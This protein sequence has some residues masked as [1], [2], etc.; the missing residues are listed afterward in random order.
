MRGAFVVLALIACAVV[1]AAPIMAQEQ[2]TK[3]Q[4][5]DLYKKVESGA[6]KEDALLALEPK[7]INGYFKRTQTIAEMHVSNSIADRNVFRQLAQKILDGGEMPGSEVYK[8][9]AGGD[10]SDPSEQS[11]M[12]AMMAKN[13]GRMKKYLGSL[14]QSQPPIRR[15][16]DAGLLKVQSTGTDDET[17]LKQFEDVSFLQ[18]PPE[19]KLNNARISIVDFERL[20]KSGLEAIIDIRG[21][22]FVRAKTGSEIQLSGDIQTKEDK[23]LVLTSGRL[24]TKDGIGAEIPKTCADCKITINDI[25][26]IQASGSG[27]QLYSQGRLDKAGVL[28]GGA[29]LHPGFIEFVGGARFENKEGISFQVEKNT[30]YFDDAKTFSEYRKSGKSAILSDVYSDTKTGVGTRALT[31]SAGKDN[32]ITV[33]YDVAHAYQQTNLERGGGAVLIRE[34]RGDKLSSEFGIVGERPFIS[35]QDGKLKLGAP[36]TFV[37]IKGEDPSK[38]QYLLNTGKEGVRSFSFGY[39]SPPR[40]SPEDLFTYKYHKAFDS[41]LTLRKIPDGSGWKELAL[42]EAGISTEPSPIE[43]LVKTLPSRLKQATAELES[44]PVPKPGKEGWMVGFRSL[45]DS[46]TSLVRKTLESQREYMRSR[47]ADPDLLSSP[48]DQASL[49]REMRSWWDAMGPN[50]RVRDMDKGSKLSDQQIQQLAREWLEDNPDYTFISGD[51]SGKV[52]SRK[53]SMEDALQKVRESSSQSYGEEQVDQMRKVLK[54]ADQKGATALRDELE[55]QFSDASRQLNDYADA[56]PEYKKGG[57]WDY[58]QS[59]IQQVIDV[60]YEQ[61]LFASDESR[62]QVLSAGMPSIKKFQADVKVY[63]GKQIPDIAA[64]LTDAN[65][66]E[67]QLPTELNEMLLSKV[68]QKYQEVE[69]YFKAHGSFPPG[70]PTSHPQLMEQIKTEAAKSKVD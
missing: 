58:D 39:C 17:R 42:S 29:I 60:R 63:V 47:L 70:F 62:A 41:V 48:E 54:W 3:E 61:A 33:S 40:C 5:D 67:K 24:A 18:T 68:H 50:A 52:T 25:G 11:L 64:W 57:W 49:A 9:L 30:A 20:G 38:D 35:A 36:E 1:A 44:E 32:S 69:V 16:T 8:N 13:P 7:M 55:S 53:A 34:Y 2:T 65:N 21:N 31:I 59:V 28:S 4:V 51:D 56:H 10:I 43:K 27:F 26:Q 19:W 6:L 45:D 66:R 37:R 15:L 22:L 12:Q 23:G 14:F 46:D